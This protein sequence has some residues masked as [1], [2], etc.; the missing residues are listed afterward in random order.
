MPD[1]LDLG[2]LPVFPG[3]NR[4]SRIYGGGGM[5]AMSETKLAM[6]P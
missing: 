1:L 6:P 2:G 4:P 3:L 5:F